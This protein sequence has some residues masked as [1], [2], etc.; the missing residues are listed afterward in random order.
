MTARLP[1]S[2]LTAILAAGIVCATIDIVYACSFHYVVNDTAPTRILQAIASGLQGPAAFQ[3]GNASAALGLGAHYFILIVA[4]ALYYG[5]SRVL[6]LLRERPWFSGIVFGV[7]IWLTM[8]YVVLPLSAAPPFKGGSALGFWSNF[9]VHVLLL[10]P[11]IALT[12]RQLRERR[13]LA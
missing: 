11:V 5:V 3:G 4:A 8:N 10:G 12:L 9:A 13:S 6:P 2:P 7:G 1:R